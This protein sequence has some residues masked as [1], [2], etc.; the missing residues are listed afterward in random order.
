MQPAAPA[1]R[2]HVQVLSEGVVWAVR[3]GNGVSLKVGPAFTELAQ[4]H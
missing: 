1:S 4:N 3:H 2:Q